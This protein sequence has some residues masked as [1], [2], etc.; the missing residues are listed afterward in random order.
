MGNKIIIDQNEAI[1]NFITEVS[2]T[3]DVPASYILTEVENLLVELK[4]NK[5]CVIK[6]FESLIKNFIEIEIEKLE[7][8]LIQ[9]LISNFI[10]L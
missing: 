8:N 7:Y 3:T 9:N 2:E 10:I 1:T 4:K 6:D 5:I